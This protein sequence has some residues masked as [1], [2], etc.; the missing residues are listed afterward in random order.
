MSDGGTGEKTEEPTPQKLKQARDKGQVAKS[1]DA[2]QAL[3]FI[4][5][6]AV[7]GLTIGSL[8]DQLMEFLMGSL[9]A[10]GQSRV[11][12]VMGKG[13]AR[14]DSAMEGWPA[15][16]PKTMKGIIKAAKVFGKAVK[17][18]GKLGGK[19]GGGG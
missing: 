17:L 1:Q 3:L 12:R 9:D 6:F 5:V 11:D 8:A 15:N 4:G 2:I 19:T 14:M 7:L 13:R 16:A 10:R 18:A